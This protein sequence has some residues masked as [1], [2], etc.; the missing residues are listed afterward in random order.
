M[1]EAFFGILSCLMVMCGWFFTSAIGAI[2]FSFTPFV[3]EA[4]QSLFLSMGVG[5]LFLAAVGGFFRFLMN[6]RCH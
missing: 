4:G 2:G 6:S 5:F 1:K 3:S